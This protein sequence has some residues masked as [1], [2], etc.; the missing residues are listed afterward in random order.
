MNLCSII[1]IGYFIFC[2][3]S[4]LFIPCFRHTWKSLLEVFN[5]PIIRK[6]KN[7]IIDI[8]AFL[9]ALLLCVV[10]FFLLPFSIYWLNRAYQVEKK[11]QKE[12]EEFWSAPIPEP[13]HPVKKEYK[14]LPKTIKLR[15]DIPF[16]PDKNQVIYIENQHNEH[17][18]NYILKEYAIIEETFKKRGYNFEY[19][20]LLINKLTEY[21]NSAVKYAYPQLNDADI[22][23]VDGIVARQIFEN[24]LSFIDEPVH[25]SGGLMRYR[26]TIDNWH[27]FSY[28]QF[29]KFEENEI[30]EQFRAYLSMVGDIHPLYSIGKP[31]KDEQADFDFPYEA[32][33]LIDEIKERIEQLKQTGIGE[34]VIKS[35]FKFDDTAKISRLLITKDYRIF[36]PD[37][38]HL[39]ITMTPLPKAVYFLFLKHPEGIL[40]KHLFD[41]RDE[42]MEIYMQISNRENLSEM[43]KSIND[44]VNPT[45]NAINEKCSRIREAFINKFD[46]S[47]AKNYFITGLRLEPKRIVLDRQLVIWE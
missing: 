41:Y 40:F 9:I 37:Y 8:G 33:R 42:L 24:I 34:M 23:P 47:L 46:E 12:E 13:E 25:L 18:N 45:K 15:T 30:W 44:I 17:L 7:F 1:C 4:A 27:V 28:Y 2:L 35:L 31:E 43:R 32:Q 20:P 21:G 11:S 26:E 6:D 29:E 22:P 14:Y 38:N 10:V 16:L 5:D 19:I 3:L 36:L 39:E